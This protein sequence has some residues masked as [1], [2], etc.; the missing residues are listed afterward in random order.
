MTGTE[1]FTSGVVTTPSILNSNNPVIPLTYKGVVP[2]TGTFPLGGGNGPSPGQQKTF[3]TSKGDMVLQVVTAKNVVRFLDKKTCVAQNI[4]VVHYTVVG[5]K[6]TGS[7]A[8]ATGSGVVQV[9][10]QANSEL[11][12]KCSLAQNAGPA[13]LKGAYVLLSGAG[14]M[15]A[16]KA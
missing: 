11:H 13:T 16:P 1:T 5:G 2:A 6:S 4:T 15:T 8:G 7:F 12:G 3:V 9:L 10:F 14:P